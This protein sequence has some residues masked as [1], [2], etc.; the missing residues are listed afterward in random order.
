MADSTATKVDLIS[1][2]S[3]VAFGGTTTRQTSEFFGTTDAPIYFSLV[4]VEI[5][6]GIDSRCRGDAKPL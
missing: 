5:T 2:R 4:V 3:Q 1:K 6:I